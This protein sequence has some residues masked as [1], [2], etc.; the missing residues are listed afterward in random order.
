MTIALTCGCLLTA[1]IIRTI[2]KIGTRA[3][4]ALEAAKGTLETAKETLETAKETLHPCYTDVTW[5]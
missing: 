5:E 1:Q 2:Q 4:K 3:C